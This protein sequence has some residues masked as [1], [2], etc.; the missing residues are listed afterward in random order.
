M[1]NLQKIYLTL[2]EGEGFSVN[3]DFSVY[4]GGGYAVGGYSNVFKSY[5]ETIS[6]IVF[7]RIMDEFAEMLISQDEKNV[8]IG[9]W[10]DDDGMTYVE[11]SNIVYDLEVAILLAEIRGELAIFDFDNLKEIRL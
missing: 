9:G 10:V 11:V 4:T 6:Y 2:Q 8:V 1:N 7:K 5:N 3:S